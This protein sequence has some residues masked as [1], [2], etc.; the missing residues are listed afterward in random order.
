MRW[1]SHRFGVL[2]GCA[3]MLLSGCGGG[4]G[5]TAPPAPSQVTISG[6]AAT[7]APFAGATVTLYDRNGAALNSGTVQADGSYTLTAPADAPAPLVLEAVREDQTLVSTYA[8][9]KST[10]LNITPLTHLIAALLAPNGDPL[11]LRGNAAGVTPEKLQAQV[12]KVVAILRPLLDTVGDTAN[13]LTG[14]FAANGTGHDKVLD[15]ISVDIRPTGTDANIEVTVK[16][17]D[18]SLRTSF[19][20]TD[21][22]P[23][24]LPP[25]PAAALPPDNIAGMLQDLV[26]RMT[27]CYGLPLEQRVRGATAS[28]S[29]VAGTAADVEAPACRALFLADD[30]Q[31]YLSSG[32]RVASNGAFS[33]LFSRPATGVVFDLPK[34]LFLR[35]NETRDPVFTYR[36][37]DAEGNVA[38][39]RLVARV[40]AGKLKLVGNQYVYDASVLP[41]A[42]NREFIHQPE[43]DYLSTGYDIW[44]TNVVE[45]GAPIFAKVVVTAPNG[46]TFELKPDGGRSA[47]SIVQSG[48][49]VSSTSV[50][51]LAAR[52]RN[53]GTASRPA[54]P[55]GL[56][57]NLVYAEQPY[58]DAQ[59][60]ELPENGAWKLEFFHAD[61][62]KANV[63]QQYR[64]PAR[65]M[66]L[67]EAQAMPMV[68]LT[69]AAIAELRAESQASGAIVFGPPVAGQ[70]QVADLSTAGNNDFWSVPTGAH[71]PSSVRVFGRSSQATGR[72]AYDD[73]ARVRPAARKVIVYCSSADPVADPH[74]DG[75]SYAE[76]TSISS[77]QLYATSPRL[78]GLGRMTAL[79]Y[80]LPR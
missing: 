15:A 51:R 70:T 32:R 40:V 69:P 2:L 61:S 25:V 58:S 80:P 78:E 52:F 14:E 72:V 57:E 37:R 66:T 42:Q 18:A 54:H 31:Q 49:Q 48:G 4:G 21:P 73:S 65:A 55:S 7:G 71:A 11:G 20:S 63:V 75:A 41:F 64:T 74:C 38:H 19:N 27:T 24:P 39:D 12:D 76:G 8:E 50:I 60:R 47:L 45:A 44:V 5:G 36:W 17:S 35:D 68:Q 30:P 6:V 34:L 3:A 33:G 62:G 13:P 43:A 46:A 67:A 23:A 79:Y 77:I 28:A 59:L 1:I 29:T 10:R 26:Q 53:A 16:S 9:T 56:N 22:A